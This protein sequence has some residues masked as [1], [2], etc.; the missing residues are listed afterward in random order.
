MY[1]KN[2]IENLPQDQYL[3]RT[4]S[5]IDLAALEHNAKLIRS[6]LG[7]TKWLS[8]VKADAYGH[9]AATVPLIFEKNGA[10]WFGV[11]NLEEAIA[12]R[13][14]G[15][16]KPILIFGTTPPEYAALM[17][18]D[19]ITQAVYSSEYARLL[20]EQ[21]VQSGITLDVHIKLDTGMGR[22]GFRCTN[23]DE[24]DIDAIAA[25]CTLPGLNPTG[26]FTHFPSADE[27]DP[28]AEQ[29]TREQFRRFTSTIAALEKRDITSDVYFCD[30]DAAG[31]N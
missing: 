5:E 31:Q 29:Y 1:P 23:S 22:I 20:S 14:E 4:W 10:D 24:D 27:D 3:R 18:N 9:G 15:I 26:I 13:N 6:L 21:A 12:L 28:D 2:V 30:S 8:V 7:D 11:S 16:S 17:K 19:A 25:A